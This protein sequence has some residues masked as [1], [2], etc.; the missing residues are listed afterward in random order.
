MSE[1]KTE[2]E[3]IEK[4]K[5]DEIVKRIKENIAHHEEM[6]KRQSQLA[7]QYDH[8]NRKFAYK[9]TNYTIT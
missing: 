7:R 8:G 3:M 1:I 2:P 9:N 4:A 5:L 6:G